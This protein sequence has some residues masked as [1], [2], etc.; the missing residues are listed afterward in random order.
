MAG[1]YT[2]PKA[3]LGLN[4]EPF[5]NPWLSVFGG[6]SASAGIKAEVY[7]IGFQKGFDLFDYRRTFLELRGNKPPTITSLTA[8]PNQVGTGGTSTFTVVASDPENDLSPALGRRTGELCR[9][10]QGAALSRGLPLLL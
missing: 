6:I 4:L 8:S 5:G 3:Y 2:K 9:A 1:T 7:G 10:L